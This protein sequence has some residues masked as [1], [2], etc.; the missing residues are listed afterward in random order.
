MSAA[1]HQGTILLGEDEPEIRNYLAM[2]LRCCGY[3]VQCAE[4]GLEVLN[5]LREAEQPV[6]ALLLDMIM[7]RQGGI[8][9]LQEVRRQDPDLPVIMLANTSSPLTV[10]EAMR[11]GATDFLC[12]PVSREDLC[13]AIE[14]AVEKDSAPV[15]EISLPA[16]VDTEEVLL[17][18]SAG[19]R[20]VEALL[21][22]IA[23]SDIPVLIRGE[24]GVGKEVLARKLHAVSARKD[25]PFLKVNCA[26]LPAELVESELF[27]YERGAFTGAFHRKAGLFE[28]ADG[29]TLLLDEI[30]DMDP[31]LQA[32]LLQ[33]LQDQEFH[34]LGGNEMVRVN[35]RVLAATHCDLEQASSSGSFRP[36]L[37]YRLNV[38][39]VVVPPLRERKE[40]IFPLA[41]LFLRKYNRAGPPPVIHD[42]LAGAMQD[43]GWPGNIRELENLMRKFLVLGDADA[44]ARELRMSVEAAPVP[45]PGSLSEA[46]ETDCASEPGAPCPLAQV[47]LANDR[48]ETEAILAALRTTHWNRKQAAALLMIDY[49][50]L[51]YKMKK[52]SL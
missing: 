31:A 26:A 24:T 5:I 13:Q 22:R 2:A 36:D 45:G 25:R 4:D 8:E 16:N 35:V 6:A 41:E 1:N 43:Y 32:K 23:E 10:V 21:T 47:S 30:G 38:V 18:A 42:G 20:E 19:M 49:K 27:G 15:P 50:A 29:G 9:T 46:P 34:R 7:P 28:M 40:E 17:A 48:A 3:R 52:F 39:T 11:N 12:K 37:Y 51:L 33:V 14:R 44:L